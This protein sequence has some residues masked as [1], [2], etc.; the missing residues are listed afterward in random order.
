MAANVSENNALR[1]PVQTG[2]TDE[3]RFLCRDVTAQFIHKPAKHT[4]YPNEL[5]RLRWSS[6]PK[7]VAYEPLAQKVETIL[8]Q[9]IPFDS[10]KN[11]R[12][13]R[14]YNLS[15]LPFFHPSILFS[16]L[17][18]FVGPVVTPR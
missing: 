3:V 5:M 13:W 6:L 16:S 18:Y 15:I 1:F 10:Q 7:P 4:Q 2:R 14:T 9:M 12:G 11:F 8:A 17:V